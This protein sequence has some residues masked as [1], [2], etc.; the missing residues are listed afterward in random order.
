MFINNHSGRCYV[1]FSMCV[2][3][4]KVKDKDFNFVYCTFATLGNWSQGC[5]DKAN[6]MKTLQIRGQNT[7][8]TVKTL[9]EKENHT[10]FA[11]KVLRVCR[12]LDLNQEWIGFAKR[13]TKGDLPIDS[14]E[15]AT[16]EK[17]KMWKHLSCVADEVIKSNWIINVELRIGANCTR[18]SEAIKVIPSINDD[19]YAMKTVLGWCS[20][21]QMGYRDH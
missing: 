7:S 11:L 2:V 3:P 14:S 19:P 20:V 5:F 8:I 6:F 9:A 21:G 13:C 16:V 1:R 15:L 10:T 18:A 17:L 4:V 12:H